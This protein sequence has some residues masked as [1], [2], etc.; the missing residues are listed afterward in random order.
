MYIVNNV[1]DVIAFKVIGLFNLQVKR[2]V[3]SD[4]L[5]LGTRKWVYSSN[6]SQSPKHST[7]SQYHEAGVGL[8]NPWIRDILWEVGQLEVVS[9]SSIYIADAKRHYRWTL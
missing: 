4:G 1:I 5:F 9:A 6:W 7:G 3:H 2:C 8:V